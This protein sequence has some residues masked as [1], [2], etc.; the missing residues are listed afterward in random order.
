MIAVTSS[1]YQK[2]V[3]WYM[4]LIICF[5]PIQSL[6]DNISASGRAGQEFAD[7]LRHAMINNNNTGP[8]S[9]I[10]LQD[11]YPDIGKKFSIEEVQRMFASADAMSSAGNAMHSEL[12][13]GTRDINPSIP[14]QTYEIARDAK[15]RKRGALENLQFLDKSRNTVS[16]EG[17]R[18]LMNTFGDCSS[19]ESFREMHFTTHI[20]DLQHCHR[21]YKPKGNCVIHHTIEIAVPTSDIVF[22]VDNSGSMEKVIADLS[23]NVRKFASL[24]HNTS[25]SDIYFGGAA[26]REQDYL[27]NNT[28]LTNGSAAFEQW[29]SG[30]GTKAAGTDPFSAVSWAVNH[31]AWRDNA[32][33]IIVLIGNDDSGGCKDTAEKLLRE[34]NIQLYVFHDDAITKSLGEHVAD[35]FN[36]NRLLKFAQL[37]K[38]VRENWTPQDCIDDA[39]ATTE[40]FCQGT[41]R[42]TPAPGTYRATISGFEVTA[43]DPIYQKMQKPPL[44]NISKL[45]TRVDVGEIKCNY[46][47]G[48]GSCWTDPHG[49]QH[50]LKNDQD[51]DDCLPLQERGCVLLSSECVDGATGSKGRCYVFKDE[52][53][54]GE[55]VLVPSLEKVVRYH[56]GGAIR[57]MGEDCLGIPR[58]KSTD[59]ARAAGLLQV[60]ENMVQDMDLNSKKLFAGTDGDCKVAVGGIVNCCKKPEG[61]SLNDYLKLVF[62]IPKLDG[63]LTLLT[64]STKLAQPYTALRTPFTSAWQHIKHPF[65]SSFE[66]IASA[67]KPLSTP[68]STLYNTTVGAV[69]EK[70]AVLT[71]KS[72]LQT[73]GATASGSSIVPALSGAAG[74]AGAVAATLLG[75]VLSTVM[76]IYTVYSV[77]MFLIKM[78]WK[79]EQHELEMNAK[80]ALLGCHYVGSYCKNKVLGL[81]VETRESYCCFNSPLSRILQ[82]EIRKQLGM[83]FGTAQHPNC[84]GIDISMLNKIKWDQIKIDE[85]LGILH[86]NKQ[87]PTMD[88][89]TLDAITGSGSWL[90]T[91][92][93]RKDAVTRA[94]ERIQNIDVD[95]IRK[96]ALKERAAATTPTN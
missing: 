54:C 23:A 30:V 66:S 36:G 29:I 53:D 57:C 33:K 3:I 89:L 26:F 72:V 16:E 67:T 49:N 81:C 5:L 90:N 45:T 10:N 2:T 4:I 47:H 22:L 31:F 9:P 34:K 44:P 14:A 82:E 74:S 68:F 28:P 91:D 95:D 35:H 21:L 24:L 69:K 27:W 38:I 63:A 50:Q 78:V 86:K 39:L 92:G 8:S 77:S 65:T 12:A 11:M 70:L 55:D 32:R 13:A 20:P 17:M 94:Q 15:N 1:I 25:G 51:I 64:K 73:A 18:N 62:A 75:S 40:E 37:L 87:L 52:Y 79:C 19:E 85:W 60:A 41:Y 48:V 84:G 96:Q 61:I 42:A 6:A 58:E 80:R 93:K 88:K 56:C 59:F 83:D 46:N 7:S 43:G 76:T 71:G